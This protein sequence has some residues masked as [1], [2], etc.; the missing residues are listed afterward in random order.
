M[1]KKDM[2][3]LKEKLLYRIESGEM[4]MKP[5]WHF[6]LK[7][8]LAVA[9]ALLAFVGLVYLISLI[10]F[11]LRLTGI[12]FVPEFGSA[13][14][15][16]FFLAAPWLLILLAII[17]VITLEVLVQRF[18]FAY[19]KPL[20]YS[21]I[22]VIVISLVSGYLFSKTP[23]HQL[24]LEMAR[25]KQAPLLGSVY[26]NYDE[27]LM[28]DLHF[29]TVTEVKDDQF[30]VTTNQGETLEIEMNERTRHSDAL[31]IRPGTELIIFGDRDGRAVRA[32]GVKEL[33][34]D[35]RTILR[36]NRQPGGVQGLRVPQR[37]L[38]ELPTRQP[39]I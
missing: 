18:A 3:N 7:S 39:A 22:G 4:C 12:A 26:R 28:A 29:G 13:G 25:N 5:K 27:Q 31:N 14:L 36:Q 33:P 37:Q 23:A 2:Q 24:M 30:S 6:M 38:R 9:G 17:F 11:V 19:Q 32:K 35:V 8:V 10:V 1:T 21:L 16:K 20:L 15:L 34:E